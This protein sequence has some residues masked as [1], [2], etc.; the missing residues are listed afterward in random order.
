MSSQH[1][2]KPGPPPEP[3]PGAHYVDPESLR[4]EVADILA[5]PAPTSQ[6]RAEQFEAAHR[7][8]HDAL[9]ASRHSDLQSDNSTGR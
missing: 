9:N 1:I 2:P 7:V 6:V 8:L 3:T 4:R 5:R